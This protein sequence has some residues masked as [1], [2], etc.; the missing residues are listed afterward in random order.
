MLDTTN[1][2]KIDLPY[3]G[4][5]IAFQEVPDEVSLVLNICGCQHHCKGCHSD[6]LWDTKGARSALT[7]LPQVLNEYKNMTTCVCFMGGEQ[8]PQALK[9]A[10]D[11]AKEAGLKTCLYTGADSLWAVEDFLPTLDYVKVGAYIDERGGLN[12]P[13]TNQNMF[14]ISHDANKT[15][16]ENITYRFQER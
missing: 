13:N 5:T 11:M 6:Y 1:Q 9:V 16:L 7:D 8:Y 14:S 12:N 15:I 3:K 4:Y 2:S 10:I